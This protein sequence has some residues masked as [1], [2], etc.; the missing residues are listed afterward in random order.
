ME[1]KIPLSTPNF[2][3]KEWKYIKECLDDG[4][5]SS[6]GKFVELF[7]SRISEYTKSNFSVACINGTSAIHISLLLAGV[8][9][10]DE[11]IVP[12]LTF[13]APINAVRYCNANPVFMDCDDF[14]NL[15]IEK[16][17]NFINE[18]TYTSKEGFAINK[19]TDKRISALLVTHVFGNAVSLHKLVGICKKRKIKIIEDASESLGT[20]YKQGPL[21]GKHTGTIGSFGCLSFNGNKIITAGGGGMILTDSKSA[22]KKAKYLTTQAKNDPLKYIHNEIGYNYRLSNLQASIGVAQ[23]EK[24]PQFLKSKKKIFSLYSDGISSINGL[25]I[26]QV[27]KFSSNNHWINLLKI[28]KDKYG[29]DPQRLMAYLDKNLIESRPI[30]F[31]NHKQ[32]P[33]KN[34]Q[35]YRIENAPDLVK[36]SLCLPSSTNLKEEDIEKIIVHLDAFRTKV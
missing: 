8:K 23:L 34:F 18:E 14:C 27:P 33:F 9:P 7:E 3:G 31:L 1:K 2:I 16:T 26:N 13:I 32:K 6:S 20:F 36:N 28:D 21:K 35:N 15:D 10:N 4:W 29:K 22:A 24:L 17:I 11:V 30:W 25:E 12:C 19:T 5:V